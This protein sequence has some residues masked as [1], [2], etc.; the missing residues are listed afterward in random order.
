MIWVEGAGNRFA[1]V[2]AIEGDA[3]ADPSSAAVE[4]ASDPRRPDGLLLL[5]R[6]P[7]PL[8]LPLT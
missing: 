1:L 7:C 2:D 8:R 4:L 5:D 3:P 6:V